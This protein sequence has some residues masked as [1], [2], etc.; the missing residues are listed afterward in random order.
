MNLSYCQTVKQQEAYFS[1]S[2][3]KADL[4]FL[5][6]KLQRN[7]PGLYLYTPKIILDKVFDSLE[8]SLTTPLTELEFYR[9]LTVLSSVIKDGHTIILPSYKTSKYHTTNSRFLPY[10]MV[11]LN[12][13]LFVDM[14]CTNITSIPEGSKILG[15]NDVEASEIIKQLTERQVRDGNNLTYPNWIIRN[16]FSEYYN[17]IFGHPETYKIS[18]TINGQTNNVMIN[19]LAKDTISYYLQRDYPDKV[20]SRQPKEGIKLKLE[21]DKNYAVIT[22]KDFHN[23][24]LRKEY[25]QNFEDE[26]KSYF[27]KIQVKLSILLWTY[28][29]TKGVILK[30]ACFCFP[31]CSCEPIL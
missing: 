18:Y 3:L 13:Q 28:G 6:N 5:K 4:H 22:I 24:I 12:G 26:I 30:M 27:E 2:E 31:I 29:I 11:L 8:N 16:Y 23:S 9:H 21:E 15:I 1:I 25:K 10:H 20:F 7:H 17:Y 14:V 19:A